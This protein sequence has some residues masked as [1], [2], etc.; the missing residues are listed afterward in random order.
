MSAKLSCNLGFYIKGVREE[1]MLVT[2]N[3]SMLLYVCVCVRACMCVREKDR[4]LGT[5]VE[6]W[7][8]L[9]C[10]YFLLNRQEDKL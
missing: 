3:Q 8:V 2:F 10:I 1:I 6:E 9:F 7:H 4:E 5:G